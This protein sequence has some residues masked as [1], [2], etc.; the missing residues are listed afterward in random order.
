MTVYEFMMRDG[1]IDNAKDA[2]SETNDELRDHAIDY[3]VE[4]W[5]ESTDLLD[6][7]AEL[8]PLYRPGEGGDMAYIVASST[9]PD[10]AI[11]LIASDS[12]LLHDRMFVQRLRGE[13]MYEAPEI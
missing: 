1:R 12:E 13:P 11:I 8:T 2:G 7:D 5:G 9:D 4:M 3:M 6:L 10:R